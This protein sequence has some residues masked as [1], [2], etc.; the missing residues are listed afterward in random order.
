MQGFF[1]VISE[2]SKVRFYPI[3]LYYVLSQANEKARKVIEN[4]CALI[5][6]I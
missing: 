2:L 1:A 6:S 5:A 4:S 3:K